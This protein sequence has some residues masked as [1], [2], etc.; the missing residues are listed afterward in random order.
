MVQICQIFEQ[1]RIFHST[2]F[3]LQFATFISKCIANLLEVSYILIA[4]VVLA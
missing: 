3:E 2:Q 1:L 4:L